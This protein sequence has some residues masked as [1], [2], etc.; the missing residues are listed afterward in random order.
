M[1]FRSVERLD[2]L[3]AIY[4]AAPKDGSSRMTAEVRSKIETRLRQRDQDERE[5]RAAQT[6][7]DMVIA[8]EFLTRNPSASID[9]LET[10]DPELHRRLMMAGKLPA[11][12]EYLGS[13]NRFETKQDALYE[14]DYLK[15]LT[16]PTLTVEKKKLPFVGPP[17]PRIDSMQPDEYVLDTRTDLP[18]RDMSD[19]QIRARFSGRLKIGRAHV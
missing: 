3:R 17:G 19:A 13:N 5:S 4:D 11:L 18:L 7:E 6:N 15:S 12:R 16:D 9:T 10:Q 8:Q 2:T 14:I 1:L